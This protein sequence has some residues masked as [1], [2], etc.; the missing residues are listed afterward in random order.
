MW[1]NPNP[2]EHGHIAIV[3]PESATTHKF[4][5]SPTLFHNNYRRAAHLWA[6]CQTKIMPDNIAE[7]SDDANRLPVNR[8]SPNRLE[9]LVLEE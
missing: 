1:K 3:R 9:D 8:V 7:I 6:C 4:G 2:Q 5:F